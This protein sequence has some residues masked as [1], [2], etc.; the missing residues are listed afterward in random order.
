MNH[1]IENAVNAAAGYKQALNA[2]RSLASRAFSEAKK[3]KPAKKL[4][5]SDRRSRLSPQHQAELERRKHD[6]LFDG[7][8][9]L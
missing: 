7:A 8:A 1:T 9:E 5:F 2:L 4:G 6:R 3:Q